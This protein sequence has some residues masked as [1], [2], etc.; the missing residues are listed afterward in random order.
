VQ[1]PLAGDTRPF[2]TPN[3]TSPP[4]HLPVVVN[5]DHLLGE[6]Q[7]NCHCDK[8]DNLQEYSMDD[9]ENEDLGTPSDDEWQ[10]DDDD[11]DESDDEVISAHYL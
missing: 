2:S 3:N 5:H 8:A 4:H 7:S 10:D 1:V 11:R 6:G 9:Q